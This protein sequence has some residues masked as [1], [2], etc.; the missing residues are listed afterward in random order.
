MKFNLAIAGAILPSVA[1]GFPQMMGSSKED[2]I[3][4]LKE[5]HEAEQLAKRE[6]DLI[7]GLTNTV[8]GLLKTVVSDVNGILGICSSS[9]SNSE[10]QS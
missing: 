3:K 2:M 8:G 7:S 6:P 9:L 5:R 10:T 1:L 4:M